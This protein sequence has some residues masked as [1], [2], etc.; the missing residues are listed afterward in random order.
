MWWSRWGTGSMPLRHHLETT[1]PGV[2]NTTTPPTSQRPCRTKRFSARAITRVRTRA[3]RGRETSTAATTSPS[4]KPAPGSSSRTPLRGGGYGPG[5][6]RRSCGILARRMNIEMRELVDLLTDTTLAALLRALRIS[7]RAT[8]PALDRP[9]LR[10][11]IWLSLGQSKGDRKPC[12][13]HLIP[14]SI[15]WTASRLRS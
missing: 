6:G 12:Q 3:N 2:P 5:A 4:I 11:A 10:P 14:T 13:K 7:R 9:W 15:A 8:R 1:P